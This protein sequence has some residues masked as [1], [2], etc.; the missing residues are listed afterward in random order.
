FDSGHFAAEGLLLRLPGGDGLVHGLVDPEHLGETGDAEDLQDAL[1]RADQVKRPVVRAHPLEPADQDPEARGVQELDLLHVDYQLV[2]LLVDELYEQLA[3]ARRGVDV[4][5][6]FDVND[7]DAVL[8]VVRQL[9]IHYHSSS[10]APRASLA[11]WGRP[12]PG[13][14]PRS[15]VMSIPKHTA[16]HPPSG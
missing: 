12:L 16:Q 11:S 8:V 9:Q 6:T 5:L 1:L 4:D 15:G 14:Q 7:L 10:S 3:Q 2:V 13:I